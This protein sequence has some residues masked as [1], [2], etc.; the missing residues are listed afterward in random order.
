[1]R[2]ADNRNSSI[3]VKCLLL[4]LFI[5]VSLSFAQAQDTDDEAE[6]TA[7]LFYP[8]LPQSPRIQYLTSFSVAKD[9]KEKKKKK[10]G[11]LAKFILGEE[12]PED[13]LGPEKPY[14]VA[15]HQ[16]EIHVVDTRGGGYAIFDVPDKDYRFVFGSGAASMIKPINMT[17]GDDGMKYITDTV[18]ER[19]LVFDN[20][21]KYIKSY[22]LQ[23]KFKPTDV[24]VVGDRLYVADLA[25]QRVV[26]FDKNSGEMLGSFGETGEPEALL[27]HPTN[28]AIG[29]D[30]HL[31]ISDTSYFRIQKY[32]LD[33]EFVRSYGTGVGRAPGKFAR[34]K[35]IDVDRQGRLYVVDAA[36][37]NIQMFNDEGRLLLFFG[38]K[39]GSHEGGFDLPTDVAIDYDS[40]PY[41]QRYADPSFQLEYVILVGN[42]FGRNKVS[43]FGFGQYKGKSYPGDE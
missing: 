38:E 15:L 12:N 31:Y 32:T 13:M 40:A 10:G 1:M 3:I 42:Q 17:I 33:G 35:G 28:L 5:S 9:I 11:W 25:G 23:E 27:L 6:I 37:E 41:F 30:K 16:G 39:G 34:P 7:A 4:L 22:G 24:R 36:F 29:P 43:V 26:I 2:L 19:V 20:D 8:A 18:K 14:G 21:D